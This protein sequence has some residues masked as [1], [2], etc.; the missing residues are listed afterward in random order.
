MRHQIGAANYSYI[1]IED[2]L[3]SLLKS[4]G[5][6]TAY[7]T[8]PQMFKHEMAYAGLLKESPDNIIHLAF[9]STENVRPMAGVKNVCH[10]AWEFDVMKDSG[11]VTDSILLNQVH[12]L[13]MMDE[14]WVGC[15][16]S[17][18]VLKKYGLEQT[19]V[20]PAPVVR[21]SLP[22]RP[23]FAEAYADLQSVPTVPLCHVGGLSR[24][25]N[26]DL[27]SPLIAPLGDHPAIQRR[28]QGL[29][30][31]IFLTVLNAG[32]LRKNLLNVIDGFQLAADKYRSTD[33]L[34]VKLAI[35][36]KDSFR[37]HGLHDSLDRLSKFKLAK[38]DLNIVFILDY[39]ADHQMNMLFG[40]ADFYVCA[41]HCEGFNLPL[42]Q[43]MS[44][45]AVPVST[46]NTAMHDY[47]D[48]S[49]SFVISEK[50]FVSPIAGMAGDV[51]QAPYAIGYASRFDIA[52]AIAGAM[53]VDAERLAELSAHARGTVFD[54]YSAEP[55][56][57]RVD[58]RL[59][60]LARPK[61]AQPRRET[62][63][64]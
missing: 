1:F 42:L 23:S 49:N 25:I 46:L 40:M 9:R 24:D 43:A 15:E 22:A 14:V 3:M 57:N 44:Y 12:M 28:L 55:T 54:R 17:R 11:L 58:A 61:Q 32:D 10:F 7:V 29:G 39:L 18:T 34:I 50:S 21:E 33:V 41:S 62:A 31:R 52:R 27:V 13:R 5:Y 38:D 56:L 2:A 53:A 30:S 45:G 51:A 19:Y 4:K 47:I 26:A 8:A 20:V 37:L 36:N 60:A 16:Y 48:P 63:D 59:A 64:A 6:R 35:S